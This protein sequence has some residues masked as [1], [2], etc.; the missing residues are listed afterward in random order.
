MTT[1]WTIVL[2]CLFLNGMACL[3]HYLVQQWEL[4]QGRIPARKSPIS[5]TNQRFNHWQD[6]HCQTWGDMAGLGLVVS[7]FTHLVWNGFM[8][9][10]EWSLFV[11]LSILGAWTWYRVGTH[12][13]Y[14]PNWSFP[15]TGRVSLGGMV[16][17]AYFGMNVAASTI[18]ILHVFSGDIRGTSLW[19]TLTGWTIFALAVV[20]DT[21]LGYKDPIRSQA[22][23][24]IE[25]VKT[26]RI[27]GTIFTFF[28]TLAGFV[29]YGEDRVNWAVA[30]FAGLSCSLLHMSIMTF[31]DWH[32]RSHDLQKGKRLAYDHPAAFWSY[33]VRSTGIALASITVLSVLKPAVGLF[34]LGILALGIIYSYIQKVILIN[35]LI[36]AGCG[37]SPVLCG[38]VFFQRADAYTWTWYSVFFTLIL[39]REI[40]KDIEDVDIDGGHKN[41]LPVTIGVGPTKWIALS[42]TAISGWFIWLTKKANELL[43]FL[44]FLVYKFV[45]WDPTSI[46]LPLIILHDTLIGL[47][48]ICLVV[49]EK[50]GINREL[51]MLDLWSVEHL[52]LGVVLLAS[53]RHLF[54]KLTIVETLAA[55]LA[56]AYGWE[57]L[58]YLLELGIF[59][60][61]VSSWKVGHEHWSNRFIGDPL[62]A[63]L[64]GYIQ[65][66]W[67]NA[68]KWVVIPWAT[69]GLANYLAP[70]SMYISHTII[71]SLPW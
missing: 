39:G 34:C 57:I 14:K 26:G 40:I 23:P 69:W 71:D 21:A 35:N 37:A 47:L 43:A 66:R 38:S 51:V 1:N 53:I 56:V 15:E 67:K 36:V 22:P 60:G 42:T 27:R 30:L 54:P 24:L 8:G 5:D 4:K 3:A 20:V 33:W 9:L 59:G 10:E 12:E 49:P 41:T 45:K 18:C 68:W 58:E 63:L 50:Y 62:L 64:G 17:L 29:M 13:K 55:T 16:H 70:D 61:G 44:A 31:N 11:V 32:D 6:A 65:V 28:F 19:L 7:V 52:L 46:A 25:F 48:T 2:A